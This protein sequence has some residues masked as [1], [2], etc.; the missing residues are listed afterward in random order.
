MRPQTSLSNPR[1]PSGSPQRKLR[2]RYV[3]YRHQARGF[4]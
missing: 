4:H 2:D 3:D 1:I